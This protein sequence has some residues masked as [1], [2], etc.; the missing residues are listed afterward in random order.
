MLQFF[1]QLAIMPHA[2]YLS[3][4]VFSIK[5]GGGAK[6]RKVGNTILR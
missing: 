4:Y 5:G 3:W 2:N 6:V 1:Y